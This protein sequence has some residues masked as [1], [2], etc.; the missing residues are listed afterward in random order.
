[1]ALAS[2]TPPLQPLTR[3]PVRWRIARY[4]GWHGH[5]LLRSA[6][7]R[8]MVCRERPEAE[9]DT[10]CRTAGLLVSGQRRQFI[11]IEAGAPSASPPPI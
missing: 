9:S 4:G 1:M 7:F 5:G 11:L 6:K 2:P 10:V 8:L 3:A